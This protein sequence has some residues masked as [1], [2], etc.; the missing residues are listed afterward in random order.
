[1]SHFSTIKTRIIDHSCLIQALK[2][3]N[4]SIEENSEIKGYNGRVRKGDIVI[5][6]S[7]S[8]DIGFVKSIKDGSFQIVADWYAGNI[9][10]SIGKSRSNFINEVQKEYSVFKILHEMRKKGYRMK[11][12]EI[13]DETGEIKL[14]IV[15]R[16]YSR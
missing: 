13:I 1:M 9:T 10:R 4:Y 14:V 15:K 3:L 7:G 11:S 6:T 2:K 8:F 12:R 5:K 16:G